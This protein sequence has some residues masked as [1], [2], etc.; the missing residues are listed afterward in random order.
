MRDH[1]VL[2]SV[3][4]LPMRGR[5]GFVS[6]N[7]EDRKTWLSSLKRGDEVAS[8]SR[9]D[10]EPWIESISRVR[11]GAIYTGTAGQTTQYSGAT[12]VETGKGKTRR[13][14]PITQEHRGEIER[15]NLAASLRRL[16]WSIHDLATL[17]SVAA[18]LQ[19]VS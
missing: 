14:V 13:I 8:V 18:L 6:T 4:T 2:F 19:T 12:G 3:D 16:D 11:N 17:R 10:G 5:L 7:T 1:R 9:E 15:R